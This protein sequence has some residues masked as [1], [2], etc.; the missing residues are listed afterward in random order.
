VVVVVARRW[1]ALFGAPPMVVANN[2]R[3]QTGADRRK[4]RAVS[5]QQRG[6]IELRGKMLGGGGREGGDGE[7]EE[8]EEEE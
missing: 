1:S 8:E 4:A 7:E 2:G 5:K 3:G 6:E